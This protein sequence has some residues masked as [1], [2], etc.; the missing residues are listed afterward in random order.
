M[1]VS[2]HRAVA[3]HVR[4]ASPIQAHCTAGVDRDQSAVGD[5]ENTRSRAADFQKL[6]AKCP[7]RPRSVYAYRTGGPGTISNHPES[8]RNVTATGNV[9]HA[10]AIV[11]DINL[12]TC[13]QRPA[14]RDVH[15][16]GIAR[17]EAQEKNIADRPGG[18]D[19]RRSTV[20]NLC[21]LA[22]AGRTSWCPIAGSEPVTGRV[23]PNKIC[24]D[25]WTYPSDCNN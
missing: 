16:P 24:K 21:M 14:S 4:G 18:A 25:R 13:R 10:S 1:V 23:I 9:H 17:V 15:R 8:A 2:P 11:S 20:I 3:S 7:C 6:T 5:V 22:R 12:A 19:L